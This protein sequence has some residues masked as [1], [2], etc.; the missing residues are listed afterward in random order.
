MVA[1]LRK[2]TPGGDRAAV[3]HGRVQA[4]WS[5]RRAVYLY[6][7]GYADAADAAVAFARRVDL[8]AQLI[9]DDA[10]GDGP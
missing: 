10:A 1:A 2:Y 6:L 4:A 8:A 7:T 3:R 9:E 5:K